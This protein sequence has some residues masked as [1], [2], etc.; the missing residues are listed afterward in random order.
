MTSGDG[1]RGYFRKW[2]GKASLGRWHGSRVL[3]PLKGGLDFQCKNWDS[4]RQTRTVDHPAQ[5][6]AGSLASCL[7]PLTQENAAPTPSKSLF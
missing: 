1:V 2:S 5:N 3:S 7:Q 6:A 4:P